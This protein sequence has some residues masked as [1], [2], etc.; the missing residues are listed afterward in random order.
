MLRAIRFSSMLGF[1][2]EKETLAAI[3]TLWHD[4]AYVSMERIQSEVNK[5]LESDNPENL[6]LLWETGLNKIVFPDIPTLPG[7]WTYHAQ[8]LKKLKKKKVVLLSLLFIYYC[9]NDASDQAGLFLRR[10]RYD[11]A[12]I[13]EVMKQID[14][15]MDFG[16]VSYRNIRKM[17]SKYDEGTCENALLIFRLN[18]SSY[19]SP[20]LMK[21]PPIKPALS[22]Y[23]LKE[24]G[25]C[26]KEE[27]GIMLEILSM[28]L[29]EK[30][31]LN[32]GDTL[33][34]LSRTISCLPVWKKAK[35]RLS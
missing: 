26:Y 5:I 29:Y 11:N 27:I 25:I 16:A 19:E 34:L 23:S 28:C 2:I 4:L 7:K 10:L 24:A 1:N 12:T 15:I 8:K 32:D 22:G 14:S 18:N 6:V 9:G 21:L 33:M 13:L 30:P 17:I 3:Q 31:E 20:M 35:K